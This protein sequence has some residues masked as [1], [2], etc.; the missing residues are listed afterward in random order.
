MY[1]SILLIRSR[2]P[3]NIGNQCSAPEV[4]RLG[5][6]VFDPTTGRVRA[7]S[8]SWKPDRENSLHTVWRGA[9]RWQYVFVDST[10]LNTE[11]SPGHGKARSWRPLMQHHTDGPVVGGPLIQA[12]A[13]SQGICL[14]AVHHSSSTWRQETQRRES[15]GVGGRERMPPL[16]RA[17][18][19]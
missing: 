10:L 14:A 16:R 5:H 13:L 2:Y 19:H 3:Q 7:R 8:Q 11:H 17:G 18:N 4:K 1:K 15:V 6:T 9:T 12:S